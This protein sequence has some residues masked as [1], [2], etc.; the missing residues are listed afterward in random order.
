MIPCNAVLL[1]KTFEGFYSKPY[2]CPAG[3]W[4]I[5]YGHLCS[6]DHPSISIEQGLIYLEQDLLTALHA[7]VRLCPILLNNENHLGAITDF[8]FNLGAGRLKASTLRRKINQG[9]FSEVPYQLMKWVYGG[10]RKLRGLV[11]R[12]QVEAAYFNP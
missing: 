12:R 9:A 4:T 7:T 5:G 11:L 2:L 6:K 3:F 10:G 8:T 1:A